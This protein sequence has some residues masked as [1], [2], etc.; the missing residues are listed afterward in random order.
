MNIVGKTFRYVAA[1]FLGVI[2]SAVIQPASASAV[3]FEGKTIR[4]LVFA[5]PGGG[6]DIYSRLVTRYIPRYLPGNPRIIV[7]NMPIG[8]AAANTLWRAKPNGLTWGGDSSR[9]LSGQYRR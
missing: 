4:L 9:G 2:L 7:Q 1:V 6:Y 5:T 3:S 8:Y